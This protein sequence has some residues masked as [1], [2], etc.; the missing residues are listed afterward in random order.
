MRLT[1]AALTRTSLGA[2]TF[3][4]RAGY[5]AFVRRKAQ[6]VFDLL[7]RGVAAA[8]APPITD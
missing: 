3:A 6:Q 2:L 7:N 8:A 1:Y 5:H 4:G